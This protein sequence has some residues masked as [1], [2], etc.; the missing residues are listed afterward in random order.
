MHIKLSEA[1][2]KYLRVKPENEV[3][4]VTARATEYCGIFETFLVQMPANSCEE[5]V[6]SF[7]SDNYM[8]QIE[9]HLQDYLTEDELLEN[10]DYPMLHLEPENLQDWEPDWIN[11]SGVVLNFYKA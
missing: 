6:E 9:D 10:N 4:G 8:W 1:D 7:V 11:S 5:D 3:F 2:K